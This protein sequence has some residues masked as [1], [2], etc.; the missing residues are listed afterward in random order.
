MKPGEL[1]YRSKVSPLINGRRQVNVWEW[2][3]TWAYSVNQAW[4][5]FG[6]RFPYPKYVVETPV[7]DMNLGKKSV[8]GGK[9]AKNL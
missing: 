6:I 1:R 3:Y 4:R 2:H 8:T 5:N 7:V 9:D